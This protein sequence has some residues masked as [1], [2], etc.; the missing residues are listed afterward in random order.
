MARSPLRHLSCRASSEDGLRN[1]RSPQGRD[2]LANG[3]WG[4]PDLI[5]EMN[6]YGG[7]SRQ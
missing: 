3:T 5:K 7:C 1:D 6:P 4:T 2:P